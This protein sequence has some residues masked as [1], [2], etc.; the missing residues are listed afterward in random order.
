MI[1][2]KSILRELLDPMDVMARAVRIRHL[3]RWGREIRAKV[4][5]WSGTQQ[6]RATARLAK[7]A[8]R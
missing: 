4:S 2:S 5:R 6:A 3:S 1:K 7:E 8:A